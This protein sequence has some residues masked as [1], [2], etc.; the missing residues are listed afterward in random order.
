MSAA[1]LKMPL[2]EAKL[3]EKGDS[4]LVWY[5][6][7]FS[8]EE[9]FAGFR[10]TTAFARQR[11]GP[12]VL[13]GANFSPHHLALCYGPIYQWVDL[14]K[15]QGMSMFWAEDYI[16]SVPEVPQV[17]SWMFAQMRC[18]AKYH[19]QPIHVYVMPHAPGQLP[20]FLRRN[21]VFSVGSGARH[22]DSFWVAPEERFTENYV[23]WSYADTFRVLHESIFDAAEVEKLQVGGKVRQARV[24]LVTGKA[25]D[26]N[27]ARLLLDKAKDPFA[28]RCAMRRPSSIRRCAARTS[29]CSTW[30]CATPSTRWTSSPRTT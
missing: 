9:V 25:T 17:L 13:T 28:G 22:L 20:G 6:N 4:R 24:A 27:E 29:R 15:H 23:A 2:N 10:A 30:P 16:F 19:H 8:E 18:A 14:F 7:L 26:F 11:F 1:E 5:S 3:T 21:M 12:D